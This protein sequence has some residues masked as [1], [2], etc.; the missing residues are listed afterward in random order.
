MYLK[1][2]H[3]LFGYVFLG[4][5]VLLFGL[6]HLAIAVYSPVFV[7][8]ESVTHSKFAAILSEIN[9]WFPYIMSIVFM[10]IGFI[11]TLY[12]VFTQWIKI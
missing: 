12:Y 4:L 7:N 2:E 10:I 1:K 3:L 5:G 9:G 8:W 11:V 6:M